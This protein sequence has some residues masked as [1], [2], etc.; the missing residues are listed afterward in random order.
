MAATLANYRCP[1]VFHGTRIRVDPEWQEAF[2]QLGMS[3]LRNWRTPVDV[4]PVS[5]SKNTVGCYRIALPDGRVMYY[6]RY[7]YRSSWKARLRF[8]MRPSKAGVEQ[9][10]YG[11][12]RRL[13]IETLNVVGFGESR[14]FGTLTA[15]FIATEEVPSAVS[16]S[17]FVAGTLQGGSDAERRRKL[18]AFAARLLGDLRKAHA[19]CLF[20]YDLKWRNI[21]IRERD[22]E[23]YPVIIDCPRA[24][25]SRLRRRYGITTD[26]SALA[27]L[28]LSYLTLYQRYR[29][30]AIYLGPAAG[31]AERKY[32]FRRVQ[33]RYERRPSKTVQPS[34]SLLRGVRFDL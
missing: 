21:L 2:A 18:S 23:Y 12:Y 24:F 3:E 20:H 29:L 34:D 7:D 32:W 11:Q 19:A 5:A 33:R 10:G 6:K 8:W 26:L 9:F 27:R 13:G 28:A 22:G 31:P 14:V 1:Q 15:A 30:L 25:V 16:L 17:D 4:P